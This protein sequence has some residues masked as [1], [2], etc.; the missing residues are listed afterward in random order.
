[1]LDLHSFLLAVA[2]V[3]GA[4]SDGWVK[5]NNGY[6]YKAIK[7]L[8]IFFEAELNCSRMNGHLASIH[9]QEENDF[10]LNLTSSISGDENIFIENAWIGLYEVGNRIW[11]WT[12]G[13]PL[14]YEHWDIGE[15][16]YYQSNEYCAFVS[17]PMSKCSL[18]RK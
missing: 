15:P 11:Q 9:S 1:M 16:N 14:D 5:W 10:V 12:D 4:T 2:A 17:S 6:E 3:G 18:L 13:S 8:Y 7:D